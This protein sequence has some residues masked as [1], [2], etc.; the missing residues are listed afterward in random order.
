M[1]TT[2]VDNSSERVEEL[3]KEQCAVMITVDDDKSDNDDDDNDNNEDELNDEKVLSHQQAMEHFKDALA[4]IIVGDPLL[5]DLHTAVTLDEV[6]SHVALEH[7]QAMTVN[8]RRAD[9]T[10]MPVAVVQNATV[11]DLKKAIQRHFALRQ[12][13]QNGTKHISW[14]YVWARQWLYFDGQKLT[15]D[16]KPIK[17]YGIRNKD[18][19]TFVRRLKQK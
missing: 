16:R 4:E 9:D 15:D 8:V 17:E 7:G 11:L 12:S 19:V 18:E 5:F 14:R 1:S 13:R 2:N 10:V 6:R 3:D